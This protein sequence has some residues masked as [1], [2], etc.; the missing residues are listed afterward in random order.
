M[1]IFSGLQAEYYVS[2]LRGEVLLPNKDKMLTSAA[3]AGTT[4]KM[5]NSVEHEQWT[6]IR[7][8]AKEGKFKRA[9]AF[10]EIGLKLWSEQMKINPVYFKEN[11]LTI[12]NNDEITLETPKG[13]QKLKLVET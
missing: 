12:S 5:K 1:T 4:T 7:E 13:V 11:N 8:L 2:L 9:P 6:Y 3:L 10:Y